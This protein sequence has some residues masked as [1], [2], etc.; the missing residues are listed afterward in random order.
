MVSSNEL[1]AALKYHMARTGIRRASVARALG[2]HDQTLYKKIKHP[3]RFTL[4]ELIRLKD[5]FGLTHIEDIFL[6][7][8]I[9]TVCNND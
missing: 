4:D 9:R 8:T 7:Q 5:L 1:D 6:P 3:N 2:I